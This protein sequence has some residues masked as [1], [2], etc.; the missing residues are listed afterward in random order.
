[1][2]FGERMSTRIVAGALTNNGVPAVAVNAFEIGLKTTP[3]HG[4]ATPLAGIDE[5]ICSELKAFNLTPVVTGFLGADKKGNITTLG[6]SG[7]DFSA[8]IIGAAVNAKE[9]QIWTDVSGVMTCDPSVDSSAKSLPELSFDE[10]SE[11]AYYGAEVIHQSTLIPLIKKEIPVRVLN[12]TN[13]E[14]PGTRIAVKP[15]LTDSIAKS[16]VYKED[17]CLISLASPRLMSAVDLL[18]EALKVL[19]EHHVGIRMATT[20]EATVSMVTDQPYEQDQLGEALSDLENLGQVA[21]EREKAI[22]CVIGE[23]LKGRA[24][25]LGEIF[26]AVSKQGIKAKMVSQSASELN[27]AFLVDNSEIEPAVRALHKLI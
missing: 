2:S 9:V 1:M 5:E 23:E 12:T 8:S 16:I 14:D 6:R 25:V 24:G 22:I 7:S 4:S 10:A 15:K 20:S 11:L 21:I 26:G 19:S 3:K 27:V 18:S 13:P 17:V